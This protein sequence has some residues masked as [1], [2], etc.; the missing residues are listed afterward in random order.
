MSL[1]KFSKK[2]LIEKF[3]N[4]LFNMNDYLE[5]IEIKASE[6]NF[7]F[8]FTIENL[9][10]VEAYLIDNNTIVDSNDYNDISAYLGEVV[11]INYGGKWICCLDK[12]NNSLYYGFPVIEGHTK[13]KDL[14]FSPFH[15]V[16]SFILNHKKDL[17]TN[18][19]KSQVNPK[20]ID[21][22]KFPTE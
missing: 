9:N 8:D 15:I 10:Q 2:D 1:N 20:E 16:R 14:L 21:W 11:R 3:E 13:I 4:F 5:Q 7:K 18:A 22:S 19:I 6:Q 17:F 12:E